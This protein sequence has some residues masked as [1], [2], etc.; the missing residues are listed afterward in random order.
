[1][2]SLI[3]LI[4]EKGMRVADLAKIIN[5]S[6]A[7]IYE[8][9]KKGISEDNPHFDDLKKIIP[10]VESTGPS[11]FSAKAGRKPKTELKLYDTDFK[12]EPSTQPKRKYTDFPRVIFKKRDKED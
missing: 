7:R 8:W 4:K 6:P 1:M 9:N 11:K 2:S 12:L 5:V 3:N 10:E